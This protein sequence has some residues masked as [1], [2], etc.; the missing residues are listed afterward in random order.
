MGPLIEPGMHY[1]LIAEGGQYIFS[2]IRSI[3]PYRGF[4]TIFSLDEME[5]ALLC[6]LD[7]NEK[8]VLEMQIIVW[9]HQ[10]IYAEDIRSRLP[11]KVNVIELP[12]LTLYTL[13]MV[14]TEEDL[15]HDKM[16]SMCKEIVDAIHEKR[17]Q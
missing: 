17:S 1:E 15:E 13:R 10:N 16:L 4:L 12:E 2:E 3:H 9:E 11:L 6:P 5:R 8:S 14:G 7:A